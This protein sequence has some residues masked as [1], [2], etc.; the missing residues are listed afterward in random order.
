MKFQAL[1][2]LSGL[3]VSATLLGSLASAN[4]GG[5]AA[6]KV[7]DIRMREYAIQ[8]GQE[9]EIKRIAKP[10]FKIT[11]SGGEAK[12]LQQVLPSEYSV[13]TGMQPELK[14]KFNE[15]FKTLGIYSDKSATVSGKLITIN[16][17]D[18][19]LVPIE[20]QDGKSKIVKRAQTDCTLS[21]TEVENAQ[22]ELGDIS[23]FEPPVC[24]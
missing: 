1:A 15:T 23:T 21:I 4:D 19:D 9:K 12:K 5:V 14:D 16:C 10:N 22:D 17:V 7:N 3:F 8:N 20:G 6:I 18:G 2:V 24:K 11:F 13:I